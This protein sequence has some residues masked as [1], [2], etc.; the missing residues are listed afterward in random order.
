MNYSHR[1]NPIANISAPLQ[2]DELDKVYPIDF[3]MLTTPDRLAEVGDLWAKILETKV[4]LV[5][6]VSKI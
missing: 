4:D 5:T 3:N 6:L 1:P 2:W